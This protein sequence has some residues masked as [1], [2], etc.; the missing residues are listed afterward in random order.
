[1]QNDD[2]T[3][4]DE[5]KIR[6]LL[7]VWWQAT[8]AGDV[9]AVLD[10]MADDIVFLTSGQEPFGKDEFEKSYRALS[11]QLEG[12]S[13]IEELEIAN[14]WAWIR[15]HISLTMT[16]ENSKPQDRAGHTLTILRKQPDGRW[17]LARDANLLSG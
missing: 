6:E 4:D 7:D 5:G 11:I 8:A 1:M 3:R 2:R 13:E 10:L 9:D 16:P 14:G 15:T 12:S 17:L